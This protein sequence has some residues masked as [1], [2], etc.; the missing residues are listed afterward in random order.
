M[1]LLV[2]LRFAQGDFQL[3]VA[4]TAEAGGVT[5]LF[6]PSGAGKS[7][8]ILAVA[9]LLPHAEGHII[10]NGRTLLDSA[11]RVRVPAH[12]RRIGIVFQEGRLFPHLSVR[13]NLR[14]GA[15]RQGAARDI[16]GAEIIETLGIGHLL[17][18]RPSTLSG[19]ER[20][21]VALG[22]ALL[23]D[24][25]LLLLDEPLA[26][27]DAPRRAEILPAFERIRDIRRIPILYVS[28]ST[29]EIARLADRVV[30]IDK[31]RVAACG[32]VAE[33]L[34]ALDFES[35]GEGFEPVS[36]IVG[37]VIRQNPVEGIT[38]L[39]LGQATLAAPAFP[40][41]LGAP[42]RLRIFARDV[43]I[44]LDPPGRV[45]ANNVLPAII[46][47]CE[48]RDGGA[49][50]ELVCEGQSIMAQITRRAFERLVLRTGLSVYAVIK[51]V[52]IAR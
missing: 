3:E 21:R 26:A 39:S 13:D 34:A 48:P 12:R 2:D 40:A 23:S 20:Q 45:S 15:R 19:G 24:P 31:G 32:T 35:G 28:H 18:R 36:V 52:T 27:L 14:Y 11:A 25:D 29:E 6:G 9:G 50:V 46:A 33:A 43:M 10:L 8:V 49:I 7:T 51:A 30:A 38:D 47:R 42:V 41:E 5:A 1:T 22:R 37:T 17:D 44:A 4:L 16:D